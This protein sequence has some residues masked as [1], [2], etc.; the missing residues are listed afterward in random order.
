MLFNISRVE[1]LA[2]IR[3]QIRLHSTPIK[4]SFKRDK[5]Q[6]KKKSIDFTMNKGQ[7]GCFSAAVVEDFD[8]KNP[9]R[10]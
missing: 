1:F 5:Q 8:T 9:S 7:K 10:G 3:N 4:Y 6:Q 2:N